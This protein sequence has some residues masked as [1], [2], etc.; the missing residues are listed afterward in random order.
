MPRDRPPSWRAASAPRRFAASWSR[1]FATEPCRIAWC[2]SMRTTGRR[3][4]RS[5]TS[6]ERS[7]RPS[8][9]S[10]S[11][12]PRPRWPDRMRHGTASEAASTRPCCNVISTASLVTGY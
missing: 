1:P 5:P 8:P 3:M 9:S 10:A 6:S 7:G 11:S 12:R 2:S 4:R